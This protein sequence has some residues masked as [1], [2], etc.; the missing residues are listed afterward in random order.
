MLD[1]ET[2][3][4]VI[5]GLTKPAQLDDHPLASAQFVT[6]YLN[7][8]PDKRSLTPGKRLG[9]ALADL[10]R[11]RCQPPR[12]APEDWNEWNTFLSL[13]AG[14][15]YPFRHNTHFPGKPAQIGRALSDQEHV[16]LLIADN[17]PARASELRQKKY[18]DFWKEVL[19]DSDMAIPYST[20]RSRLHKALELLLQKLPEE[21]TPSDG[22]LST[23][24]SEAHSQ[25][26]ESDSTPA[27]APEPLQ[28]VTPTTESVSSTPS[29]LA[30]YQALIDRQSPAMTGYRPPV[31]RY[32][33]LGQRQ[34]IQDHA[35]LRLFLEK[36]PTVL[37]SGETGLGKTTYLTQMVVSVS[38]QLNWSPIIIPL[39][40]Y[41]NARDKVGDLAGFVREQVFGHWQPD[42]VEKDQFAR[43]LAQAMREQRVI[44]LLDGYDE[45]TPRERGLLNQELERLERFVVTTR[46]V[47]PA[48]RR[49]IEATLHLMPIERTEALEYVSVRYSP[50]ARSRLEDWCERHY[51]A[52]HMLTTGWWLAETAQLA[53]EPSQ[54][55]SLT[56]VLDRAISQQLAARARVQSST[57]ADIYTLARNALSSLAFE[58]LSPKRLSGEESDRLSRSQLVFAWRSRTTEPEAIFFE[59]IGSTGLLLEAGDQW[60]FPNEF[61]CD[62]LA[63]E[64]IQTEGFMLSGRALYPQFERPLSFWA[65]RLLGARQSQRVID[66]LTTLRD[67][68]DD[69]YGARWSVIVRIL[70]ECL[71]LENNR[72]R[73]LRLETEQALLDWQQA[74]SSNRLKWQINFWLFAIGTVEM[75]HL[76]SGTLEV[77]LRNLDTLQPESTLPELLQRAGYEDLAHRLTAG[78]RVDQQAVTHALIDLLANGPVSLVTEAAIHLAPR[79][80]E[81]TPLAGLRKEGPIDRLANL[82]GTRSMNQYVTPQDFNRARAAQSAALGLLGRPSVL[83]NESLLKRIPV[84]V[85]HS[86][87]TDLRLCIRKADNRISVITADGR[88]WTA[89]GM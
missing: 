73:A 21:P 20:V 3:K 75:P 48:G 49:P 89:S 60:R 88:D 22:G 33:L 63:A 62:E 59:V 10:W 82:A 32:D 41:F 58:S 43:E 69:P 4:A 35:N 57:S 11:T 64:F 56:S 23:T 6:E 24:R 13:E 5:E 25:P 81:P 47:K 76:S 17:D 53:H 61:V 51:E 85:I 54:A 8:H 44:W 30:A 15:F 31:C 52:L 45:L 46:Q 78:G 38:R 19:P 40:A 26:S 7:H 77:A 50:N 28:A 34:D 72:L 27:A 67:L 87:M 1:I 79:P 86:L 42:Q 55:L 68:T 65:A 71:P 66:L 14:Y 70:T 84:D 12:V 39:P 16:A 37:I 36:H 83:T 80:L 74:T 18:D 2:L 9:W 29:A